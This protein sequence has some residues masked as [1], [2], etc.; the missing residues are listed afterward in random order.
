MLGRLAEAELPLQAGIFLLDFAG[1]LVLSSL[2]YNA[3]DLV[4]DGLHD[5][6]EAAESVL[7]AA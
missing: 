5:V 7:L 2:V 3:A 1:D 4:D 6:V